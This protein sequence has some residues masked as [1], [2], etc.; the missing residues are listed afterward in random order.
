M[1]AGDRNGSTGEKRQAGISRVV[2]E[3]VGH[4]HD[5]R[6]VESALGDGGADSIL[7]EVLAKLGEIKEG[8]TL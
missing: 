4:G 3:Q 5:Q 6:G 1:S 7:P 8:W 2:V